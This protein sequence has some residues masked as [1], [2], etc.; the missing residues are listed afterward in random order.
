MI[1]NQMPEIVCIQE[2]GHSKFFLDKLSY[3]Y[4]H[5]IGGNVV[6][7]EYEIK[8]KGVI[9]F[10][11]TL[12]RIV[13]ADLLINDKILR[14][15]NMHL[16]S[17]KVSDQAEDLVSN[18]DF[19]EKETWIDIKSVIGKIKRAT[20]MRTDQALQ[21]KSFIDTSPYPTL[22]LGDFNDTPLSFTYRQLAKGYKD[23]FK[24]KGNGIG[25]TYGGA[26][27]GLRIDYIL[28]SKEIEF[29]SYNCPKVDLSDH[30]P[31]ICSFDF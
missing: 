23:A 5:K 8:D 20:N 11:K 14:V 2:A 16:Q 12:N 29:K 6:L 21:A 9:K 1:E 31:I 24:K 7:S 27:P 25:I 10:E 28:A 3:K 17:N 30:Y 18:P 15:I 19:R 26:V 4:H 22:V 13:W